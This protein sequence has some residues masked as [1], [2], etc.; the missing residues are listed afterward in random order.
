MFIWTPLHTAGAINQDLG[1][2]SYM[3]IQ[4][5]CGENS[6]QAKLVRKAAASKSASLAETVDQDAL[7]LKMRRLLEQQIKAENAWRNNPC[8]VRKKYGI[9][10]HHC[11][12]KQQKILVASLL[13]QLGLPP[14]AMDSAVGNPLMQAWSFVQACT[15]A[16]LDQ[17]F[18]D[19]ESDKNVLQWLTAMGG[20]HNP[21]TRSTDHPEFKLMARVVQ[22]ARQSVIVPLQRIFAFAIPSEAA[23]QAMAHVAR[24]VGGL[25]E[26][27]A[28]TGYWASLLK[29]PPYS[30]DVVAF[31]I[32]PPGADLKNLFFHN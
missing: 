14:K 26:L 4:E 10:S 1:F 30:V 9:A 3:F 15:P 32:Q 18:D 24:Q 16:V 25:I 17:Y 23:L 20:P 8:P 31:D 6:A 29:Q 12:V 19:N 21:F 28:G 27:G 7:A 11:E 5:I 13:R 22:D 2:S